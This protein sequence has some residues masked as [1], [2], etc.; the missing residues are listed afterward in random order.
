MTRVCSIQDVT[1]W[2]E[3]SVDSRGKRAKCW[4]RDP[5]GGVWLRKQPRESRP[6]EPAIELATLILA[7]EASL[8]AAEAQLAMWREPVSGESKRGLIVRRFLNDEH[9]ELSM[10]SDLLR[11][12]DASYDASQ[13]HQHTLER[14]LATLRKHEAS[15]G[16]RQLCQT[17]VRLVLFDAWIGNGDRH[18][19]NWGMIFAKVGKPSL[20]PIY[21]TAACLGT[22]LQDGAPLLD[23]A[24]RS[25]STVQRYIRNCPSGFGDGFH[26]IRQPE[27]VTRLL[28]WPDVRALARSLLATFELLDHSAVPQIFSMFPERELPAARQELGKTLLRERL[29]WLTKEIAD[30]TD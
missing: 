13:H 1:D 24:K 20:A 16:G 2:K 9:E 27:V 19:E 22:E 5:D 23:P 30:A 6:Y 21:D 12:M 14:V 3:E 7:K 29:R 25:G 15:D 28:R 18:P 4:I 17:F 26:L 8:P 10:G 11:G